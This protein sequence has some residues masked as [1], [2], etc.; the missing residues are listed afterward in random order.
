MKKNIVLYKDANVAMMIERHRDLKY[1]LSDNREKHLQTIQYAFIHECGITE[2]QYCNLVNIS[3]K[4]HDIER[5][6]GCHCTDEDENIMVQSAIIF[7]AVYNSL[8]LGV[9]WDKFADCKRKQYTY[10]YSN[11]IQFVR[12]LYD[13]PGE[14]NWYSDDVNLKE[15][16]SSQK[17]LYRH[18]DRV[19]R[20][21]N[22][23]SKE[24]QISVDAEMDAFMAQLE[25]F[26]NGA[27]AY[28]D[29]LGCGANLDIM[30]YIPSAYHIDDMLKSAYVI[31]C[32]GNGL[33]IE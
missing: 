17:T 24:L 26:E 22:S 11:Y 6:L 14:C 5:N 21:Y 8:K 32:I 10:K 2:D 29:A 1:F 7:E 28:L 25:I 27:T 3:G 16:F 12:D 23:V 9:D 20:I 31:Y 18:V 33:G 4:S 19:Y 15:W 30:E 13:V